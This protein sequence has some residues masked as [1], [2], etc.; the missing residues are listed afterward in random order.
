MRTLYSDLIKRGYLEVN[1]FAGFTAKKVGEKGRRAFLLGEARAVA[2]AVATRRRLLFYALVLEYACYLRPAEMRRLRFEDFDLTNYTVHV[3]ASKEKTW[4]AKTC[5]IPEHYRY[6]FDEPFWSAYPLRHFIFGKGFAPHASKQ[7]GE[8]TMNAIHREIL[9]DLHL[10]GELS[11]LTG[12]SWYSWKDTGITDALYEIDPSTVQ[13]QAGH[14]DIAITMI[15]KAKGRGPKGM[16]KFK[17]S[18]GNEKH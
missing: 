15:Y 10:S 7:C 6:L 3:P 14:A 11:D 9:K 16:A 5:L 4:R 13:D 18:L 17:G 2:L 8:R 1:P 12:L